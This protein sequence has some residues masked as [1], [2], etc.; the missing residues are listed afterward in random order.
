MRSS[1]LVLAIAAAACNS[2]TEAPTSRAEA[3][4]A[5]APVPERIPTGVPHGGFIS[6]VA[7]TEQGDAA[8]TLDNIGGLRLWPAL[9]GSREPVPFSINGAAGLAIA[10]AGSELLVGVLDEAG[11]VQLLRFSRTGV[12]HGRAQIP[13][14]VAIESLVAIDGG[15]LVAREDQAIERYDASAVLRG[16]IAAEAGETLGALATRHGS[17][18]VLLLERHLEPQPPVLEEEIPDRPTRRR[19]A[20]MIP[21][22]RATAMRWIVLA[23][24]SLRWG[25]SIALPDKIDGGALALAP[26]HDRIALISKDSEL[27][28]L[29]VTKKPTPVDGPKGGGIP[30]GSALGFVDNDRVV[31]I[32][33]STHWWIATSAKTVKATDPWNIDTGI[34]DESINGDGA[35][36]DGIVVGGTGPDLVLQDLHATKY[37]GWRELAT[38]GMITAGSHVGLETTMSHVIWLDRALQRESEIELADYG[39]TNRDRSWWLD[40]N[41]AVVMASGD[42]ATLSLIDFRHREHPVALGSYTYVQRVDYDETLRQLAVVDDRVVRRFT[43]DL[44]HGQASELQALDLPFQASN[45][46]QLDPARNAGIVAIAWGYD[47]DGERMLTYREGSAKPNKRL[48]AKVRK[49]PSSSFVGAADDG[50]IY[51]HDGTTVYAMRDGKTVLRF[52]KGELAESI[53]SNRGGQRLVGIHGSAVTMYDPTGTILWTQNVWGAQ[54]T[55]FTADGSAIL[56]RTSGGLIE[57]DPATGARVTAACGFSFGVMTKTPTV[58]TFNTQPVCEDLGT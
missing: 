2:V 44:E 54:A 12:L 47:D 18:G 45:L 28:V 19:A 15:M 5:P 8:V 30:P 51:L 34:G 13:G 17:A 26:G 41:H 40:P 24:Q 35:V 4:V 58:N 57:L 22:D 16:R 14:E 52:P 38:G 6:H 11:A 21:R 23:D 10:H 25:T 29:D 27:V 33:G 49:L 36:G 1:A 39:F 55:L 56:V 9:D 53:V 50:T 46:I 31:R 3:T 32:S 43:L 48:K 42:K 20:T 37:L 7:V